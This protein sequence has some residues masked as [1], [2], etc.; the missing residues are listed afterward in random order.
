MLE[1]RHVVTPLRDV[2]DRT[3]L[4]L[5]VVVDRDAARR[6]VT[7]RTRRAPSTEL[8]YDRLDGRAR[9]GIAGAARSPGWSSTRSGSRTLA[10]AIW[11]R[12]H[13][14]QALE[15]ADAT[16]EPERREELL[17]FVSWGAG[18]PGSRRWPRY[19]TS[20]PRRSRPI[21]GGTP[22]WNALDP[23]RGDGPRAA[24]DRPVAGRLRRARA[25]QPR[26]RHP[27]RDDA[28]GGHGRL[29]AISTGEVVGTRTVSWTAGVVAHPGARNLGLTSMRVAASWST[30]TCA[31]GARTTSGR[32]VT[33]AAVPDP[34]EGG[35]FCPPTSQH[36]DPAGK[37][38]GRNVAASLGDRRGAPFSYKTIGAVRQPRPLQGGGEGVPVHRPRVPRVVAGAQLPRQS[39]PRAP[40]ARCGR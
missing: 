9:L 25:A 1:P 36:A 35:R 38:A 7:M 10:D 17:T 11:L 3:R 6:T 29:G 24:R 34:R 22:A 40:R 16:E 21:P 14:I 33:A 20:P 28:R 13:V 18:T 2:L 5:G 32:S 37:T 26:H 15:M 39:D 23:D 12:N 30:S 8:R 19:R 27:A 4:R 31:C